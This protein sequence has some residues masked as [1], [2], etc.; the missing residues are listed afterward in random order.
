MGRIEKTFSNPFWAKTVPNIPTPI[1][2]VQ[3]VFMQQ[4]T[5]TERPGESLRRKGLVHVN[6]EVFG[7]NM[8][9]VGISRDSD[10]NCK[11]LWNR[12]YDWTVMIVNQEIVFRQVTW[13]EDFRFLQTH[14]FNKLQQTHAC[15]RCLEYFGQTALKLYWSMC[16]S[17]LQLCEETFIQLLLA[18]KHTQDFVWRN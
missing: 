7:L 10:C 12:R 4:A 16:W 9:L 11:E 3:H 5:P 6:A 18:C 15:M 14:F 1:F 17:L 2:I 8:G 13:L